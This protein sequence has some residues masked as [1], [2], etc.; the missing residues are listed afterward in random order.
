ML[1]SKINNMPPGQRT[2]KDPGAIFMKRPAKSKSPEPTYSCTE[3]SQALSPRIELRLI[4]FQDLKPNACTVIGRETAADRHP[5][6]VA[7]LFRLRKIVYFITEQIQIDRN[8]N[9]A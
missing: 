8:S 1:D 7:L 9:N 3:E 4:D 5:V 2:A 6:D